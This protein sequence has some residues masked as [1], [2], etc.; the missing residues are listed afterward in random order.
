[1]IQDKL[2]AG[3]TLAILSGGGDTPAINSS[4]ECVRNRASMLGFKVY[5]ILRGW[6]GLLGD[7]DLVDL[8]NIP[9]DGIYGG[10][11]LLSS[12]T[13]PFPSKKNPEDRSQQI[14]RNIER[15]KIDVLVT[16]GGDDTNG[17]AKKM[18]EKYGI[19]V[20]GFPKTIDNDLRGQRNGALSRFRLCSHGHKETHQQAAHH[21]RVAPAYHGAGGD[22]P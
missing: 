16:I 10:T 14:L 18:Y 11:G 8:T 13:N 7:G 4:I 5:G 15:Y 6:K 17:A 12:R 2:Y 20:I 9:Y 3:K 22:G 21:Q 19:P 1:M